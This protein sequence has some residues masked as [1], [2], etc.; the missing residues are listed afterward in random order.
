MQHVFL[1]CE[2]VECVLEATGEYMTEIGISMA[3]FTS[4]TSGGVL[5]KLELI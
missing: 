4:T 1:N 5:L 2:A 3:Q